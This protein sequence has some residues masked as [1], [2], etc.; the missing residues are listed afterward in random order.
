MYPHEPPLE[1]AKEKAGSR[2]LEMGK[3]RNLTIGWFLVL[4]RVPG[5]LE[6]LVQIA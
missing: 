1:L 6:G 2:R 5:F 4:R 3:N